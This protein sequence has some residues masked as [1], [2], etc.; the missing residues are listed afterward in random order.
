VVPPLQSIGVTAA[1]ALN[2]VGCVMLPVVIDV[3]P[4]ASVTMYEYGPAVTVNVP[5][6]V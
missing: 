1:D 4:F 6:P 2:A 3:H 5:V